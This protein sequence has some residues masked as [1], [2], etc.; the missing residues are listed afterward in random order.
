MD[1]KCTDTVVREF[2]Y[3]LYAINFITYF[4]LTYF[5][6]QEFNSNV[7]T[8]DWNNKKID[9]FEVIECTQ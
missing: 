9:T 3:L 6:L 1:T 4:D 8:C 5:K 2:T 7:S